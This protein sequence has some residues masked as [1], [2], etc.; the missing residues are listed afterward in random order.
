MTDRRSG[1]GSSDAPIIAGLSPWRTPVDLFLEK[2]GQGTPQEVTLPMRAGTAL[3]GLVI[4]AFCEETGMTVLDRQ[5]RFVDPAW[6]VRWTTADGI[7]TDS[8]LVEAKTA[9]SDEGWGEPGTDQIPAHYVAQVQHALA[10]TE[11]L[12][13]Y[14]PVL[15]GVRELR[16]YQVHRD[17]R[18]I[19]N[20]TEMERAFWDRVQSGE[21]PPLTTPR[22][23]RL[24][25]PKDAG[26]SVV[27]D[28]EMIH[29]CVTLSQEIAERKACDQMVNL[30]KGLIQAYM[31]D[32]ANL[33][34]PD[35]TLLATWK[36]TKPVMKFDEAAFKRD[37]PDLW[38]QY[39]R[40]GPTQ[41]RF[42]LKG[43]TN[44]DSEE[45]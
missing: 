30:R 45:G 42:L 14:V 33:V 34:D 12:V 5:T 15:I 18:I 37:N 11:L 25:Y 44:G 24:V 31:V 36:T 39:R 1:L 32:A 40:A 7:T 20:L 38:K 29:A 6:P 26:T 16:I 19:A 28:E 35:G 23:L 13:A 9:S 10:C 27:A 17:D 3:E 43:A 4:D 8:A 2:R 22:E 21:A 41:R